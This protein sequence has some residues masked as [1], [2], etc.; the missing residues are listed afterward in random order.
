MDIVSI[1][2]LGTV[3]LGFLLA[4]LAFRLLSGEKPR[5][6][7]IYIFMLFCLIL[8]VIG[9]AL[10][11][12][13]GDDTSEIAIKDQQIAALSKQVEVMREQANSQKSAV[14]NNMKG[15]IEALERT[16][17]PIKALTKHISDPNVCPGDSDGEPLPHV[18]DDTARINAIVA[19]ISTAKQT[20]R[21]YLE[22]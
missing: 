16:S 2:S 1:L 4:F 13:A 12:Y 21:Q 7:P 11:F 9:A 22:P 20:A 15:L 10:Q 14:G 6:R 18:D 3:G 19:E 17:D 8:V 5:E